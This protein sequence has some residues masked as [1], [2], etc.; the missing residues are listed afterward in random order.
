LAGLFAKLKAREY[1]IY[2]SEDYDK[3]LETTVAEVASSVKRIESLVENLATS[4]KN[5]FDEINVRMDKFETRMDKF[6]VRMDKFDARLDHIEAKVED[7]DLRLVS[8][9]SY[10]EKEHGILNGIINEHNE[11]FEIIEGRVAELTA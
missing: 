5:G 10:H 7:I 9:I 8:Q 11:R 6:D 4:T 2:M 1:N 3:K